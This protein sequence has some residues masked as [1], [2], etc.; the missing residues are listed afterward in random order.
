MRALMTRSHSDRGA[1]L[2]HTAFAL[3]ALF[4]FTGFVVD[5]GTMWVSRNQAQN[6]ADAGAL[7]GALARIN[8]DTTSP[9]ASKTSG[10]VWEAASAAAAWNRVWG[11]TVP[12]TLDWTCPDDATTNCV[13]VDAYSDGT[14]G[15][16]A[17]PTF[18]LGLD[19]IASQK[20][21]A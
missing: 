21:K 10:K 6:A 14:N 1:I 3:I 4:L 8:D 9:P 19:G 7:A 13:V 17:L 5:Y 2:V 11:T 18:F 15:S 20:M 16:T 12:V